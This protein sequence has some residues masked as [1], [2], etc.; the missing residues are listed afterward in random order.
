MASASESVFAADGCNERD[1]LDAESPGPL[2]P[3]L[4]RHDCLVGG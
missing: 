2:L 4:P 3:E 1:V